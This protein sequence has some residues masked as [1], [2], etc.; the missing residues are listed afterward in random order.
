MKLNK[1]GAQQISTYAIDFQGDSGTIAIGA[2]ITTDGDRVKV[3]NGSKIRSKYVRI[4]VPW[5]YDLYVK[6]QY[7]TPWDGIRSFRTIE[8]LPDEE[9][10][11]L[12]MIKEYDEACFNALDGQHLARQDEIQKLYWSLSPLNRP[13][14]WKTWKTHRKIRS[15]E[16]TQRAISEELDRMNRDQKLV[17]RRDGDDTSSK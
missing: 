13:S 9:A 12:W 6:V 1:E 7:S 15:L 5:E 4:Q 17:K 11:V 10:V 8:R 2:H 3:E 14:F 16:R